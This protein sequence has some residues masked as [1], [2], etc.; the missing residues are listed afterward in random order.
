M[1]SR[2]LSHAVDTVDTVDTVDMAARTRV[3]AA[4]KRPGEMKI[5]QSRV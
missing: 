5:V 2:G 4:P 1:I 3:R